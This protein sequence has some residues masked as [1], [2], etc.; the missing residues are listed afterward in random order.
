MKTTQNFKKGSLRTL[1]KLVQF[2][3][4]EACAKSAWRPKEK[5]RAEELAF[6]IYTSRGIS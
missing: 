6:S 4:V 2:L 1:K 5:E 3:D